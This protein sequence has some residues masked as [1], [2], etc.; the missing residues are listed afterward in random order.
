[1]YNICL[2][3]I[4]YLKEPF[5]GVIYRQYLPLIVRSKTLGNLRSELRDNNWEGTETRPK[6]LE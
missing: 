6:K 2:K 3:S 5:L 4:K 1:M